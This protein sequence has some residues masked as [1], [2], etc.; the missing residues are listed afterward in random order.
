MSPSAPHVPAVPSAKQSPVHRRQSLSTPRPVSASIPGR[1][2]ER[3]RRAPSSH[4]SHESTSSSPRRQGVRSPPPAVLDSE[5]DADDEPGWEDLRGALDQSLCLPD[6]MV[7]SLASNFLAFPLPASSPPQQATQQESLPAV[8]LAAATPPAQSASLSAS[9]S[10]GTTPPTHTGGETLMASVTMSGASGASYGTVNATEDVTASALP[11]QDQHVCSKDGLSVPKAEKDWPSPPDD[12]ARARAAYEMYVE[13]IRGPKRRPRASDHGIPGW[14]NSEPPPPRRS[15]KKASVIASVQ[16]APSTADA[17][18]PLSSSPDLP[19]L[20]PGGT[21]GAATSPHRSYLTTRAGCETKPTGLAPLTLPP[22]DPLPVVPPHITGLVFPAPS[23]T[24]SHSSSDGTVPSFRACFPPKREV[25]T[26]MPPKTAITIASPRPKT[27]PLPLSRSALPRKSGEGQSL[28]AALGLLASPTFGRSHLE[29]DDDSS[30]HT[31]ILFNRA[32]DMTTPPASPEVKSISGSERSAPF[33]E[34]AM[35]ASLVALRV[36]QMST[37]DVSH[38]RAFERM[39]GRPPQAPR[40]DGRRRAAPYSLDPEDRH[41]RWTSTATRSARSRS[42]RSQS[43]RTGR[44]MHLSPSDALGRRAS[45]SLGTGSLSTAELEEVAALVQVLLSR[46][47]IKRIRKAAAA[48]TRPPPSLE[49]EVLL[50]PSPKPDDDPNSSPPSRTRGD[51]SSLSPP[52]QRD[53][54]PEHYFLPSW[55]AAHPTTAPRAH[56]VSDESAPETGRLADAESGS[57]ADAFN[58]L[59]GRFDALAMSSR[60][61]PTRGPRADRPR[62]TRSRKVK[63]RAGAEHERSRELLSPSAPRVR[64]KRVEAKSDMSGGCS[65]SQSRSG[66][67]RVKTAE[68]PRRRQRVGYEHND[69]LHWQA[70]FEGPVLAPITGAH[71]DPTV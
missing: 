28:A 51:A 5:S 31:D 34:G 27:L 6:P 52:V 1:G 36:L 12:R 39:M 61:P 55:A 48:Y 59:G 67:Y 69:I 50:T 11:K 20:S 45:T 10:Q 47:R 71:D 16:P 63:E 46:K 14:E 58:T 37:D 26:P 44:G 8:H 4:A 38:A 64:A 18:S 32:L 66:R 41:E 70:S 57:S 68:A 65:G 13:A 56:R 42:G 30:G 49:E 7:T 35:Q 2:R 62:R 17:A 60:A 53:S 33:A 23:S 19:N 3:A 40:S 22:G 25:D 15:G 9:Q 21:Q 54:S 24:G 29:M 43:S